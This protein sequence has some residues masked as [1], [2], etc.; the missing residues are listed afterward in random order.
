MPKRKLPEDP[1]RHGGNLSFLWYMA[2]W[3][4]GSV[5]MH[6]NNPENTI[7]R[8]VAL[9]TADFNSHR[10]QLAWPIRPF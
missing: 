9:V 8:A 4:G 5:F 6:T 3:N 10:H 2:W 7:V 1:E